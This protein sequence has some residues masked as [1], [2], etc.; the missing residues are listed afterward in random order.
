MKDKNFGYT[1]EDLEGGKRKTISRTAYYTKALVTGVQELTVTILLRRLIKGD[2][3]VE[4][5]DRVAFYS[6]KDIEWTR[7]EAVRV[8]EERR[9]K[10]IEKLKSLVFE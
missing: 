4:V 3:A 6:H 2:L 8:M 1:L 9:R 7:E 10:A 5:R